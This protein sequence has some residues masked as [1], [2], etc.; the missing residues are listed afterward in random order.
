MN[1]DNASD[2]RL[3]ADLQVLSAQAPALSWYRLRAARRR[4]RRRTRIVVGTGAVA[5][6]AALIAV[7][8][9]VVRPGG[10]GEGR[11]ATLGVERSPGPTTATPSVAA[12]P[13]D[14]R[15]SSPPP[16]VTRVDL[17]SS[18]SNH[19]LRG[20]GW[21]LNV[22]QGSQGAAGLSVDG[23]AGQ[24]EAS[25]FVYSR[26]GGK[27]LRLGGLVG[28]G[29]ASFTEA[30]G[31]VI[32]A[33]GGVPRGTSGVAIRDTAGHRG[34]AQLIDP[35]SHF[36]TLFYA[37]QP[38]AGASVAAIEAFDSAGRVTSSRSL[39]RVEPKAADP[40]Q[41]LAT[42]LVRLER[43]VDRGNTRFHDLC[44]VVVASGQRACDEDYISN[45]ALVELI[46]LPDGRLAMGGRVAQGDTSVTFAT[47]TSGVSHIL[48][49]GLLSG[50]P[51]DFLWV[52]DAPQPPST[53][54]THPALTFPSNLPA[55]SSFPTAA[56][57]YTLVPPPV[58]FRI[59]GTDNTG[60]RRSDRGAE[61][62]PLRSGNTPCT[63]L[64]SQ[65]P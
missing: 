48:K 59:T 11:T 27:P 60:T 7:G 21:T 37:Y 22:S 63:P 34:W 12:A 6:V 3:R 56:C 29:V 55:P 8:F 25:T 53:Q 9:A 57:A 46:R 65:T 54:R 5:G 13:V 17:G 62:G 33:F 30:A 32:V 26:V 2:D 18:G 19:A 10:S 20:V 41:L 51:N 45:E 36:D 49:L 39:A 44:L 47:A 58:Q 64:A 40:G 1:D 35:G 43:P 28:D 23:S 42:G 14:A 61:I 38:P 31:K 50:E 4:E 16:S 52:G 15:P 24:P